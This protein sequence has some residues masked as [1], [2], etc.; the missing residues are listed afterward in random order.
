MLESLFLNY[1]FLALLSYVNWSSSAAARE[2]SRANQR[3]NDK[4]TF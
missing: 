2:C 1:K 3:Q 4:T